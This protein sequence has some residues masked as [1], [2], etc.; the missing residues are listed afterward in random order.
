MKSVT[1]C[2]I[3]VSHGAYSFLGYD[4]VMPAIH[5]TSFYDFCVVVLV[6]V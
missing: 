3:W 2:E 6:M 1:T 4:I 5:G